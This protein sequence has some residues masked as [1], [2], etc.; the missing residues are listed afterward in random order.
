MKKILSVLRKTVQK[1]NLIQNN[2][3]I[4][5]GLSGGK[6]SLMLLKALAQFQKFYNQ[7]F[8]LFAIHIDIYSGKQ[9]LSDMVSFCKSLNVPLIIEKTDINNIVFNIKQESS[10]CSL[11]AKMRRGAL[12]SVCIKH[13]CN[14]LALAHHMDDVINT[15]FMSLIFE[16]RLNTM[17][18]VSYMSNSKITLIRPFY[19][20]DEKLIKSHIAE[21]PI[22]KSICPKNDDSKRK[23]IA[24]FAND[25]FK[26]FN[27]SRQNII[28][29]IISPERYNLLD[30]IYKQ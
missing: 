20:C 5:V 26:K 14:K 9:N 15:F 2:D 17:H 25:I 27:I 8:E 12:N 6:D 13:G 28:S 24:T 7:K 11:C 4:A 10:P 22:T 16:G 29:A 23:E 30:K 18:P 1:Y 19:L 21:L 3:K